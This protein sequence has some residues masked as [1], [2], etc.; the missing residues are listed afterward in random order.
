MIGRRMREFISKNSTKFYII[1]FFFSIF[2]LIS[3]GFYNQYGPE[4]YVRI[5]AY[6]I[7]DSDIYNSDIY[8]SDLIKTDN[9]LV[10]NLDS[11]IFSYSNLTLHIRSEYLR[12]N[13]EKHG[14]DFVNENFKLSK[15]S[16][17]KFEFELNHSDFPKTLK[18]E[19]I[20]IE[21]IDNKK[22]IRKVER[23]N[24]KF[25]KISFLDSLKLSWHN[26]YI[27]KFDIDYPDVSDKQVLITICILFVG[28]LT[29]LF[30]S[31]II[32]KIMKFLK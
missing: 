27:E 26:L 5:D 11:N 7:F 23:I 12:L 20:I 10:I 6:T 13:Y 22:N 18:N 15:N 19:Y 29:F 9:K 4:P 3:T 14:G 2:F 24:Y 16:N 17:V 31:G 25:G 32:V 1:L 30:G 21:L 28:I 8:N